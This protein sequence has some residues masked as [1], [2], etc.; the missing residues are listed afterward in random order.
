MDLWTVV[1]I[2]EN[3][4]I[5]ERIVQ[6][7]K[8]EGILATTRCSVPGSDDGT[9]EVLVPECEALEAQEAIRVRQTRLGSQRG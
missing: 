6:V 2:A 5:A 8:G 7:L 9:Y 4:A 1:Y 3:K